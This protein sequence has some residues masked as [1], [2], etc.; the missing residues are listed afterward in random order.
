MIDKFRSNENLLRKNLQVAA[1]AKIAQPK[2]IASMAV[3]LTSSTISNHITGENLNISG[4]LEGRIIHD[5]DEITL[6]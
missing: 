4:G 6:N 1:I 2:D 3:V 5:F